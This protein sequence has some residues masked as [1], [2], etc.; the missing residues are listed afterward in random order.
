MQEQPDV[1][2]LRAYGNGDEAAFREIVSRH[3]D[4]VYSAALRQV[5]S[6]DLAQ[7]IA[8]GV[9][10]DLV[11]KAREVGERWAPNAS[12]AGWL[13][14][15]TRFAVLNRLRDDQRR[16]KNERQA[17]EQLLTDSSPA[18][19]WERIRPVLDEAMAELSDEDRDAI[20]LRYFKNHDFHFVGHALGLSDDAAQ[21]R[22]S[23]AVD[24]LREFFSKRGV[25]IGVSG[26]VVL[27]SA[28]AVQSAPVALAATISTA[29]AAAGTAAH[30]S[31][32]IIATKAIA[33]TA[34]QKTLI[35]VT[36]AV[37]AGAG[38][39]EA[40]QASQ[41]RAQVQTFQQQ[42]TPLVN[43]LAKLEAE[44]KRL[45][46]LVSQAKDQK[47][48]S[49]SQFNELLKLRGQSGQAQTA[50][51]EL[52]KLKNAAA[53]Q[54]DET[55]N[56][57]TNAMAMGIAM[58]QKGM[59]KNSEAKLARMKEQLRLT[60]SQEQAISDVIMKHVAERSQRSQEALEA[61]MHH[62]TPAQE[63]ATGEN[64]ASEED[65]IK[66]LLTPDQ[67]AAYPGFTQSEITTAAD[68][69]AKAQLAMM[70][71]DID[72]SQEQQDKVRAALYQLNLNEKS[73]PPN[74]QAIAQARATGGYGDVMKLQLEAQK[75]SLEDKLKALDGILTPEQLA[76][77]KQ[78]QLD[79]IDMLSVGMKLMLPHTTNGAAR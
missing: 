21:K 73:V 8:Q 4:L 71:A 60:D 61:M 51:R 44:N 5:S 62:Q 74:N 39:Y 67:L 7:D 46:N 37:L 53:Q 15:S 57:I 18:P 23:R 27:I 1:Q 38:I 10:V 33:M 50:E 6:P 54:S 47:S 9:F 63:P 36:V 45:S 3:T 59:K 68:N 49:Q 19:D 11:R 70:T 35:A 52:A 55:P 24:R 14:R 25:T 20:V 77:Y 34:L 42:Q 58:A 75:Q 66:A 41:L 29:T 12:L 65:E 76:A 64:S 69:S 28:N 48:L 26:L 56:F 31:T 78:K 79:T 30:T 13:Y 32:L 17:M 43:N 22:V 72:L 16:T 2:L 40:H